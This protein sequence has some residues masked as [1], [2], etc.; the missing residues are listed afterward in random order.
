M[1]F[2]RGLSAPQ[3]QK[4]DQTQKGGRKQK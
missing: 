4:D 3:Q 1:R 2:H